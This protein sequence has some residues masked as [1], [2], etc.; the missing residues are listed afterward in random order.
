MQKGRPKYKRLYGYPQFLFD[1]V[2]CEIV[3]SCSFSNHPLTEMEGEDVDDLAHLK[4]VDLIVCFLNFD[5][6]LVH[7]F[8]D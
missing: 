5:R 1:P 8:D 6:F 3:G 7:N 4:L 2:C